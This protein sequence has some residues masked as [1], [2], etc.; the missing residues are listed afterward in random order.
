MIIVL[1]FILGTWWLRGEWDEFHRQQYK[2][3]VLKHL[4]Q[5]VDVESNA[6]KIDIWI[7][8]LYYKGAKTSEAIQTINRSYKLYLEGETLPDPEAIALEI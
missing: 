7:S 6:Y 5:T 2:R 8:V 4:K 1:L 3:I